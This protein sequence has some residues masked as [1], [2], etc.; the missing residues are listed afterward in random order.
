MTDIHPFF[1]E[2]PFI[3]AIQQLNQYLKHETFAFQTLP[4]QFMPHRGNTSDSTKY[5]KY[6]K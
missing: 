6:R 4:I 2:R 1:Q 3:F 5:K